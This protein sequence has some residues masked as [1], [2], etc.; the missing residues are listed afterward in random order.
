MRHPEVVRKAQKEIDEIIGSEHLPNL[1]DRADLP[2]IECIIKEVH[3]YAT[4]FPWDPL[5]LIVVAEESTLL[6]RLVRNT[7]STLHV[8][9]LNYLNLR[10]TARINGGR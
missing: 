4:D 2:Y 8:E 7:Q 6:H 9:I 1:E 3:R 5:W 10:H